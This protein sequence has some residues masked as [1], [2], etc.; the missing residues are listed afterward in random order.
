M[1]EE[2]RIVLPT[3]ELIENPGVYEAKIGPLLKLTNDGANL[4]DEQIKLLADLD[5]SLR[6]LF[7]CSVLNRD[8]AVES[9]ALM[10]AYYHYVEIVARTTIEPA[11]DL[12]KYIKNFYPKLCDW[13]T[14]NDKLLKDYKEG[15]PFKGPF[16]K[17]WSR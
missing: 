3:F 7:L 5:R 16:W 8:L 6:F 15:K 1:E 9:N 2:F 14:C 10:R 12:G 4:C 17:F 13:I 11:N